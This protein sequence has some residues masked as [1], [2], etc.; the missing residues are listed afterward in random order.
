MGRLGLA[1]R[2][3]FNGEFAAHVDALSDG[4]Q[5]LKENPSLADG[6]DDESED[7]VPEDSGRSDAITLLAVLQ[8]EARLVD[9]IKKPIKGYSDARIATEARKLHRDCGATLEGMFVLRPILDQKEGSSVDLSQDSDP[10]RIRLTGNVSHEQPTVG[11]L[12]HQGWQV[13]Q[14]LI[15][16]WSGSDEAALVVAAA[17][18]EV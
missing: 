18:V 2:V 10:D 7:A 1:F 6:D 9:F 12:V 15:P 3:L 17:E 4:I 13:T 8:Q 14:N 11:K 16:L 5:M